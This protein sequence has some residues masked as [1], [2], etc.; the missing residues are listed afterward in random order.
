VERL[1]LGD[2][3]LQGCVDGFALARG[4]E[5][6]EQTAY[7]GNA[8]ARVGAGSFGGHAAVDGIRGDGFDP[9]VDDVV[10]QSIGAG[11]TTATSRP[12][13]EPK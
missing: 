12:S 5:V 2:V 11:R 8:E 4:Q 1:I 7:D 3:A 6:Q 9:G 10:E 13:L